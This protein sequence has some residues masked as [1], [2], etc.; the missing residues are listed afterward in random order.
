MLFLDQLHVQMS[1][2]EKNGVN[3]VT[4]MLET[5]VPIVIRELNSSFIQKY[6]RAPNATTFNNLV[7]VLE[8]CFVHLHTWNVRFISLSSI[9]GFN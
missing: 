3:Q 1:S 5:C 6:T 9:V 4:V 2:M 8:E 7:T